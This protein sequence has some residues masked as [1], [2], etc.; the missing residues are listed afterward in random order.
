[1]PRYFFDIDDGRRQT[2]DDDGCEYAGLQEARD[3]ATRALPDIVRDVVPDGSR[4]DFV[5]TAT[6][7]DVDGQVLFRTTLSLR[8]EWLAAVRTG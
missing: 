1:M 8:T 3:A 6:I 7:R 2:R 4:Q 5:A